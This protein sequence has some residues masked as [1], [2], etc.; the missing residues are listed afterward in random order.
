MT[1]HISK[2]VFLALTLISVGLMAWAIIVGMRAPE[3]DKIADTMPLVGQSDEDYAPVKDSLGKI[4]PVETVDAGIEA[5][6][7][8]TIHKMRNAEGLNYVNTVAE[9]RE[10]DPALLNFESEYNQNVARRAVLVDSI[11]VNKSLKKKDRDAFEK[12]LETVEANIAT[13]EN[14]NYAAR[15][16]AEQEWA[17]KIEGVRGSDFEKESGI[18]LEY[19]ADKKV[20]YE[21]SL[22][23]AQQELKEN[24]D[25]FAANK[26]IFD[27]ACK[28]FE[29]PV[30]TKAIDP[31]DEESDQVED[32]VATIESYKEQ[33]KLFE[34]E[35]RADKSRKADEKKYKTKEAVELRNAAKATI[36][37]E[38]LAS[39]TRYG[40]LTV[41]VADY[42]FK[43]NTTTN[44]ISTI[45]EAVKVA[46]AEGEYLMDL[47]TAI[48][49]NIYWGYFLL[50]FAIVFVI[51]GFILNLIHE[52]NWI[53]LGVVL[54]VV[55]AVC[56]LA[57]YVAASHGWAEG[58]VLP[59]LDANGEST[60]IAFG[61]GSLDSPD[62]VIFGEREYMLADVSIWITYI[63]FVLAL[64]AA[65]FSW[66]WS[67]INSI[68][69]K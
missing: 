55:A 51:V 57:Y 24:A 2:F 63:A 27:D 7:T 38:V 59:V 69:K 22:E 58:G 4:V 5:M 14:N 26:Q 49:Y 48:N 40:E 9:I 16:K 43:I 64:V 47:A 23:V 67:W 17:K 50:V 11:L 46:K 52:P 39:V 25:L 53:K 1:K 62:R 56:G 66:I 41:D 30:K 54:L 35:V 6:Y 45:E 31:N 19:L 12:E 15:I 65:V 68:I 37:D 60:G 33:V 34:D 21:A 42:Q 28:T 32:Y 8:A 36:T 3:S 20:G 13:F 18:V 44:N 61:L 29:V 10:V